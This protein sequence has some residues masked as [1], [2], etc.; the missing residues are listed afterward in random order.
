MFFKKQCIIKEIACTNPLIYSINKQTIIEH[1]LGAKY[2][3]GFGGD[4]L[5]ESRRQRWAISNC[6]NFCAMG[7]YNLQEGLEGGGGGRGLCLHR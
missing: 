3:G 7:Q 4:P 1:L 6:N 5:R 2:C